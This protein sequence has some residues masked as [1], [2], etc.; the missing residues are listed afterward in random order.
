MEFACSSVERDR[1]RPQLLVSRVN[2]SRQISTEGLKD[3]VGGMCHTSGRGFSNL[4]LRWGEDVLVASLQWCGGRRPRMVLFDTLVGDDSD[5]GDED[6][7][8]PC[9]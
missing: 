4:F 3:L 7:C 2:D 6:A 1:G 5:I 9:R 8:S